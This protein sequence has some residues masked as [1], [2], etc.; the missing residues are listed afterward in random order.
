MA[1]S[2]PASEASTSAGAAGDRRTE[3]AEAAYR[4]IAERGVEGMSMRALARTVGATTGLVSHH[5]VDRDDVVAA[6]LDHA[7]DVM[8]SRPVRLGSRTPF[9]LLA[10]VLPTDAEAIENW[11]FSV[12]VR[13]AALH[14]PELLQFDRR[15]ATIWRENLPGLLE[16]VADVDPLVA[17]DHL[18]A[19]QPDVPSLM[20]LDMG[21]SISPFLSARLTGRPMSASKNSRSPRLRVSYSAHRASMP[22]NVPSP[23]SQI[24]F[25]EIPSTL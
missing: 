9:D 20:T 10:A 18:V 22:C 8:Q 13:S 17:T 23:L 21:H 25:K 7:T 12:A 6:A 15:V 19:D 2:D 3:L 4:L 1:S 5:F 11:R 24:E 14:D 16:G